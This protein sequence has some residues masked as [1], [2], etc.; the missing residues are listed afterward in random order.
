MAATIIF[1]FDD[2]SP[3]SSIWRVEHEPRFI[4]F[5]EPR[6]TACA[7]KI[8]PLTTSTPIQRIAHEIIVIDRHN[9]GGVN[10]LIGL[11]ATDS[12]A[13]IIT[14]FANGGTL[15]GYLPT[16]LKLKQEILNNNDSLSVG[17]RRMKYL[18]HI[19]SI[20]VG[21]FH[22]IQQS[23]SAKVLHR[24]LRLE[25]VVVIEKVAPTRSECV[26]INDAN[27]PGDISPSLA[28]ELIDYGHATREDF[29]LHS[30]DEETQRYFYCVN[31][32]EVISDRPYTAASEI[33]SFG[34]ILLS[35]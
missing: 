7:V 1:P 27:E 17:E 20:V 15:G 4:P 3:L 6:T 8:L 13:A 5:Q 2:L 12:Y 10:E 26:D 9:A 18:H 19:R 11:E 30:S 35:L 33:W 21:L 14:P 32:P 28:V 24:D 22:R 34:M 25:N 31:A 23:L 29:S 16:L